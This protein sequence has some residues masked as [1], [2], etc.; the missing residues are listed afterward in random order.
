[1]YFKGG[2]RGGRGVSEVNVK[3]LN[4]RCLLTQLVWNKF[5]DSDMKGHQRVW[6]RNEKMGE[7]MSAAATAVARKIHTEGPLKV[8]NLSRTNWLISGTNISIVCANVEYV[9]YYNK[10]CNFLVQTDKTQQGISS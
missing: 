7:V 2:K 1:M 6:D 8:T 10:Q 3:N 4:N 9:N 5:G